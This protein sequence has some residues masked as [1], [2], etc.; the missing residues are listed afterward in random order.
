M[1][2]K[3]IQGLLL[4]Q[5]VRPGKKDRWQMALRRLVAGESLLMLL[6]GIC[7]WALPVAF[8]VMVWLVW[9]L[10]DRKDLGSWF[11][12][13]TL[14]VLL[15]LSLGAR[16]QLAEGFRLFWNEMGDTL[17]KHTG[18]QFPQ[19]RRV[20]PQGQEGLCRGI[21]SLAVSL[22]LI[23]AAGKLG[24]Q[25][26]GC[27]G[28]T[29]LLTNL[30]VAVA[31]DEGNGWMILSLAMA[32]FLMFPAPG[33]HQGLGLPLA[34]LSLTAAVFLL[35]TGSDRLPDWQTAI[36]KDVHAH[37]YETASTTLPEGDLTHYTGGKTAVAPALT[38]T[39]E[40]PQT[41]YLRGFTG[42]V[43]QDGRWQSLPGEVLT[44]N[45][46]LL[47]WLKE[48]GFSA[49][50]QYAA[51]GE[52][53]GL[54][55]TQVTVVNTGA[56]RKWRYVPFHLCAE[57]TKSVY[58]LSQ[59]S[60]R[61]SGQVDTY[62]VLGTTADISAV[63]EQIRQETDTDYRRKES[64]Y[65]EFV[66]A[67]YLQVP[68]D[69]KESLEGQWQRIQR[70]EPGTAE[71]C[72]VRFLR[73]C[74]PE[75]GESDI[76]L[77]LENAK[78][79]SYQ[80]ATVAVMTLRYFGIPARY[81]EGYVISAEAAQAAAGSPMTVDSTC[82]R[83]WVEVYQDGLGWIPMELTP[84]LGETTY[85]APP[86]S[87]TSPT[88]EEEE[89]EEEEPEETEEPQPDTLT[90]TVTDFLQENWLWLPLLA[91]LLVLAVVLRRYLL[92]H[93]R[94]ARFRAADPAEAVGW[95]LADSIR[96]LE[97]CGIPRENGS[98]LAM[99]AKLQAALGNDYVQKFHSAV[100]LNY[101]AL[102][103]SRPMEERH[104]QQA[105]DFRTETVEGFR[106][107]DKRLRFWWRKWIR[108]LY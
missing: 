47:S 18:W 65:R 92:L 106:K 67:Q 41:L 62:R 56:C 78:G 46:E 86:E 53:Q 2:R 63:L 83:A 95:I 82:A 99:E 60:I 44:E 84:G 45:R 107:R 31:L 15:L 22:V 57:E 8:G 89:Q 48:N 96:I 26:P 29:L 73:E 64:A 54:T 33:S 34:C 10:L 75:E 98:L 25:H 19:L 90:G 59:G 94:M 1:K 24:E 35:F 20:L 43:W 102:F 32:A 11:P 21:F 93:R 30:A 40:V 6:A 71:S 100:E 105:L 80:Y 91:V 28:L 51:A 37:L 9:I 58:D 101:L 52:N 79:T 16:Q 42:E 77:P 69:L 27:F 12:L 36:R 49:E 38:V 5:R 103:S 108:C 14:A 61:G 13:G 39:M 87:G 17:L 23:P 66:Y 76:L 88:P 68:A 97:K 3:Q 4:R 81:A 7:P 50:S 74:F 70:E 85:E 55:A 104:R 72:A